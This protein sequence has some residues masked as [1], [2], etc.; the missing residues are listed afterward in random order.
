MGILH[1]ATIGNDI[2]RPIGVLSL[3]FALIAIIAGFSSSGQGR[4]RLVEAFFVAFAAI[5]IAQLAF[6]QFAGWEIPQIPFLVQAFFTAL[7]GL[8]VIQQSFA[9]TKAPTAASPGKKNK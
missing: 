9:T 8:A 7:T 2:Y 1:A 4:S 6:Q 3:A 5:T